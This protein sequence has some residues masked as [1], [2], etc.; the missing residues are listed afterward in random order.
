MEDYWL[1]IYVSGMRSESKVRFLRQSDVGNQ[2]TVLPFFIVSNIQRKL[3]IT[4]FDVFDTG[5]CGPVSIREILN[6]GANFIRFT[7]RRRVI[8]RLSV[9]DHCIN[10]RECVL[11]GIS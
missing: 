7:V 2:E 9:P 3:K 5:F 4:A 6:A 10:I 1:T 11:S 8:G